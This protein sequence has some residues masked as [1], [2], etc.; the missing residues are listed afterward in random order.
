MSKYMSRFKLV[1]YAP[2]DATKAVDS[3]TASY[4]EFLS[5]EKNK[6]YLHTTW[7]LDNC[8]IHDCDEHVDTRYILERVRDN[9]VKLNLIKFIS[10][11]DIHKYLKDKNLQKSD[12]LSFSQVYIMAVKLGI[13]YRLTGRLSNLRQRSLSDEK[14]KNYYYFNTHVTDIAT[15]VISVAADF[16]YGKSRGYF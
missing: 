6:K 5:E 9:L 15:N 7:M 14:D 8:L 3:L 10:D 16:Q 2:V 1:L 13:R 4:K 11:E 12:L